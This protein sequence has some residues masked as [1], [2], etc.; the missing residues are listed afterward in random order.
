VRR[1][2]RSELDTLAGEWQFT[3]E[4]AELDAFHDLTG[5]VADLLDGLEELEAPPAVNAAAARDPGRKP[6]A[7]EDPFNAIVRWCS[8]KADAGGALSGLRLVVKDCIAIAGVPMTCGS[9]ILPDFVPDRDSAVAR[10][11]LLAGAE[12]VGTA[13]MDDLAWSAGG[14]TGATG[15]TLNPFDAARSA[16]GSSGGCAAALYYDG[17]DGAIGCDQGGSIRMPAAWC[18]VI[19]LK[20]THGLVPYSGIVGIDPTLDHAGPIARDVGTVARLLQAIAGRDI[21][22]PRQQ[23]ELSVEDYERA[24]AEAPDRLQGLKLGVLSEGFERAVGVEPENARA[25]RDAIDR[26]AALGAEVIE[27][28]VPEHLRAAAIIFACSVEGMAALLAGGGN[29]YH[30]KGGYWPELAPALGEGLRRHGARLS[31]HVKLAL[32][33][34]AHLRRHYSGAVYARAQNLRSLIASGYDRALREADYLVLPTTPGRPHE[35]DPTLPIAQHVRRDWAIVANTSPSDLT[36]H[37]AVTLPAA[38]VGGL[39]AGVM[40]VGRPFDEAGLLSVGRTYER[41][42]GWAPPAPGDP[43]RG[44]AGRAGARS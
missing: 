3:L 4:E 30:W 6:L 33:Y 19:G 28:S 10:R 18:G 41:V 2:E 22:D 16:G 1:I 39:P 37:P 29:G 7:E 8:V 5:Y 11:L 44:S 40:L 27:L 38:E 35:I 20:P 14:D 24:V 15:P 25:V 34:G 43:R 42:Y 31:P 13:S 21:A 17:V 12:I 36:G 26:L 23:G 32:I 9:P